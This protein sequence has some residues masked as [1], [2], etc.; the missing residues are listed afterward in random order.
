M[1]H[2]LVISVIIQTE[3]TLRS[4]VSANLR[5][6]ILG[7]VE[8]PTLG[9]TVKGYFEEEDFLSNSFSPPDQATA[10]AEPGGRM[11]FT[12]TFPPD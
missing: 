9:L 11:G 3:Q 6:G 1:A 2:R 4:D 12:G 8:D 10:N 5:K 7:L